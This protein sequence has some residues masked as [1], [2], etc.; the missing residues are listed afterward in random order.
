MQALR[1][2]NN[3]ATGRRRPGLAVR[4]LSVTD[5][6]KVSGVIRSHK[7][8]AIIRSALVECELATKLNLKL[9]KE[10]K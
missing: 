9:S 6:Q 5:L 8:T 7:V 10:A 3:C 2:G 4:C 1:S